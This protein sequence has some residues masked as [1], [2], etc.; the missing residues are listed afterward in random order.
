MGDKVQYVG[1][2]MLLKYY[3]SITLPLLQGP[4]KWQ[5]IIVRYCGREK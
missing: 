5:P 1:K 4:D 2:N 3:S